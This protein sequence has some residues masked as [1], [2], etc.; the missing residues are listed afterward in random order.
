MALVSIKLDL[1]VIIHANDYHEFQEQQEF[2][3]RVGVPLII[4][5]LSIDTDPDDI[6]APYCA[7][8]YE[9]DNPPSQGKVEQ[10]II[11]E[12]DLEENQLLGV[13]WG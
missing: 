12:F 13:D 6:I 3:N 9:K 11:Q 2:L 5:E 4:A 10:L 8:V 7:M 1:P